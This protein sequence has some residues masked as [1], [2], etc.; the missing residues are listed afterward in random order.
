MRARRIALL[1][2]LAVLGSAGLR[3]RL[4]R[5]E[6]AERSMQPTLAPGDYVVATA[7][8]ESPERGDIVIF[9]HPHRPGFELVKRIV[10]LPGETIVIANGQIHADDAILA[11]P[12]ADGPTR[13]DGKWELN[14]DQIFVLGDNRADSSGDSR[15]FGPVDTSRTG[16]KVIYRYWPTGSIGRVAL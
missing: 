10:G 9:D 8:T 1:A 16:W 6:I 4:R 5:Y 3:A 12:W 2:A 13:P 15:W 7:L 14:P 11:E